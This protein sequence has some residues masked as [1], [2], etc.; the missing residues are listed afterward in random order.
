MNK[1]S[2][3]FIAILLVGSTKVLSQQKSMI[4][5]SIGVSQPVGNFAQKDSSSVLYLLNFDKMHSNTGFAETGVNIALDYRY[6]INCKWGL[7]IKIKGQQN[8]C[9]NSALK[10]FYAISSNNSWAN[11]KNVTIGK[12]LCGSVL[13][14]GYYSLFSSGVKHKIDVQAKVMGVY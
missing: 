11:Q 7:L 14:G 8:T 12:W 3:V 13:A 5:L 2:L 1:R 4:S 6:A 10:N 9:N